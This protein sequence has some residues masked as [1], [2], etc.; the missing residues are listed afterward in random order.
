MAKFKYVAMDATGK[1]H[2][3]I[4]DAE[5]EADAGAKLKQ[6]S[7]IPTSITQ[8]ASAKKKKMIRMIDRNSLKP[9]AKLSVVV[10]E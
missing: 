9:K 10:I 2:K 8:E 7:M 1:E 6:Q 3:G 4:I 5:S